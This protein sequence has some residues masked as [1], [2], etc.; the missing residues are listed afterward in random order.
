MKIAQATFL[1]LF[2]TATLALAGTLAETAFLKSLVTPPLGSTPDDW[3]GLL[4]QPAKQFQ[5]LASQS[6]LHILQTVFGGISSLGP[7]EDRAVKGAILPSRLRM[8]FKREI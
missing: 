3:I 2:A 8:K 6:I 4:G 5:T 7:G 1:V